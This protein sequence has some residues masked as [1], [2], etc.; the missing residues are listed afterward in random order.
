[1]TK[2]PAKPL[3]GLSVLMAEDNYHIARES[4]W[5]LTEAGARVVGPFASCKAAMAAVQ[6]HPVD[7]AVLDL[8]LDGGPKFELARLLHGRGVPIVFFTGYDCAILPFDLAD[9]PCVEKP[10]ENR[11]L[12]DAVSS[13]CHV[14]A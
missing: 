3:A 11:H 9:L 14:Q 4:S 5:A 8:N 6:V 10:L 12:V 2:R 7:C 13:A 1:M